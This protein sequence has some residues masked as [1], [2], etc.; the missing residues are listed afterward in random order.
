MN[1]VAVPLFF[2]VLNGQTPCPLV[3]IV[4][5]NPLAVPVLKGPSISEAWS[6]ALSGFLIP[7]LTNVFMCATTG[8]DGK[9][10]VTTLRCS[11]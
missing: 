3:F 6:N 5:I 11:L 9:S 8:L 1:T 4:V 2:P 10:S 7:I